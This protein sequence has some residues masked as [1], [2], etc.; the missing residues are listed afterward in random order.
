MLSAPEPSNVIEL[1]EQL[2]HWMAKWDRE[3]KLDAREF[4][5]E[6]REFLVDHGYQV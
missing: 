5:P 4:Y 1:R 2:T 3:F 6:Y